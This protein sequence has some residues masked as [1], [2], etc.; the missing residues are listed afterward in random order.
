MYFPIRDQEGVLHMNRQNKHT[1]QQRAV[2]QIPA[3]LAA[4]I[5]MA[6]ITIWMYVLRDSA[7]DQSEFFLGPLLV[8]GG[9]IFWLLY[10]HIVVCRDSLHTLGFGIDGFWLDVATGI[11]LGLGFLVL[12]A[13]T[14]PILNGLFAPRPPNTEIF[15]L[16]YSISNNPWL[17]VLWLGPVV[18]IGI[19]GFEELWRVFVLRRLWN[20]ATGAAGKWGVLLLISALVGAAHG[21]QGPAAIISIGFKSILMAWF[22]MSTGRIRPL[23]VSH[24]IYDSVQIVMAVIA[25]RGAL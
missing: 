13:L 20:V 24:A 9:F 22:F 5:P 12:R 2:I 15:Q 17:L 18:W 6:L 25:I 10:L 23:I 14:Q 19:A 11:G 4:I 16:I 3:A 1:M 8:G 21:Y 7:P